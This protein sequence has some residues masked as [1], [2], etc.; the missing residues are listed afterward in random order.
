MA[1]AIAI[2]I[3]CY[4][5]LN[6]GNV[7]TSAWQFTNKFRNYIKLNNGI[8]PT[9]GMT[10]VGSTQCRTVIRCA[11]E[12]NR[13][14]YNCSC[15]TF[16]PSSTCEQ[17][18]RGSGNCQLMSFSNPN[19]VSLGDARY[20]SKR[21]YVADLCNRNDVKICGNS[22]TCDIS[23]WPHVCTCKTGFVGQFCEIGQYC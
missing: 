5:L 13:L 1:A 7:T 10:V 21:F 17:F 15:F 3:V 6:I 16:E 8:M 20:S 2:I 11:E 9:S 4:V 12:C 22:G 14:D 19:V 23:K 18:T